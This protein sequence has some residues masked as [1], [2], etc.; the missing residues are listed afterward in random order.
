MHC[1]RNLFLFDLD[2]NLLN[3]K[4]KASGNDLIQSSILQLVVDTGNIDFLTPWVI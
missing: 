3:G 4:R 1:Q 2:R